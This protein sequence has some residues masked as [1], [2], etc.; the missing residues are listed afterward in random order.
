MR[1][2]AGHYR[3]NE[4]PLLAHLVGVASI[5]ASCGAGSTIVAAGLLHGVYQQG[6][7]GDASRG[8][9]ELKRREVR[10]AVG[11]ACEELVA[12][13][14]SCQWTV[15]TIENLLSRSAN[16]PAIDSAIALMKLADTLE[17]HHELGF[18]YSPENSWPDA[19]GA[20]HQWLAAM[21]QLAAALGHRHL[22]AELAQ[23]SS[24]D[25]RQVPEFLQTDHRRSFA[26]APMSHSMRTRVRL[27][28][29]YRLMRDC[30]LQ[31]SPRGKKAA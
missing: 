6:E 16:L 12:R 1:V 20:R 5:L 31:A 19:P 18:E 29:L 28:R 4:K 15:A 24:A 22:A 27:G 11:A 8:A 23:A 30:V 26:V 2:V 9:S 7:F 13:Y 14:A 25:G 21:I 3:P 10:R 17:D